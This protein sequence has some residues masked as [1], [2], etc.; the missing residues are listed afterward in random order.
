M[1][2]PAITKGGLYA[3]TFASY[4]L[5]DANVRALLS[6]NYWTSDA[7]GLEAATAFTYFFPTSADEY[8]DD[9]QDPSGL[10]AFKPTTQEQQ[11]ASEIG[12]RLITQFTGV[13][14]DL[15]EDSDAAIRVAGA[16]S[17]PG[18][19]GGS[20]ASY[21]Y[22][23]EGAISNSS[24]DVF[25]GDN[26]D[27]DSDQ[28][29][30]NDS[31]ATIIHE[32]GHAMGLK[33]P[34]E[35]FP[36][37]AISA[38]RSNI[39]F[40]VMSYSSFLSGEVSVNA[41]TI[42]PNG[43]SVSGYMMYDI[44]ALQAMYGANFAKGKTDTTPAE[45]SVYT[46]SNSTGQQYIN[47]EEAPDTGTTE[48]HKIFQTVW[49]QGADTTYD[50]SNFNGDQYD[51]LRAGQWLRFSVD[52]LA[53]LNS[54]APAG[55]PEYQAHGNVYNT[56][57]F[58]GE[59]KSLIGTLVAGGGN[60]TIIGNELA[61]VLHG[62]GGNDFIDG[63]IGKDVLYGGAGDDTLMGSFGTNELWGGEGIDTASYAGRSGIVHA[64][65]SAGYG[66]VNYMLADTYDSI[67]NLTAGLGRST[68]VGDAGANRLTG[69]ASS[70]LLYG[71][72]GNDMLIGGGINAG[73]PN[74][75][76]GQGGIDTASYEG[77]TGHVYADL[78]AQAGYV[79]GVLFDTMN[80]V[81][82]LIGGSTSDTL[83]GNAGANVLTG[84]G[85]GDALH[86]MGGA[87]IFVYL[88]F[89]D[90][91]LLTGYDTIFDFMSGTS[92]LDLTAFNT[93]ASHVQ[94]QSDGSSTSLYLHATVDVFNAPTDLAISFLGAN[95]IALSDILFA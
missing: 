15:A 25:L 88:Q 35:P 54:D 27:P 33:H 16:T 49:T 28:L 30:G 39:E 86:G 21:P 23:H 71:G 77:T 64:D 2:D 73:T 32:I 66:M 17:L 36:N 51:D 10:A 90:S 47:G 87:D 58:E 61:N 89:L 48:T 81:E 79:D 78:R 14:F 8:P 46:W 80:S 72:E 84:A 53:D 31:F 37:G 1:A 63:G 55:T 4:T 24:G 91:N 67:E 82:N 26:G 11:D 70:D 9:Y 7:D 60:D 68:L 92:K 43:S 38:D 65:L 57:L 13:S 83:I 6:N 44:A 18:N 41:N 50:L 94:I 74:Q 42:A 85:G 62:N 3:G 40:T 20:H 69:G 12:F 76:W 56:L 93:N 75:L 22:N 5:V 95:A 29:Y 34:F 59:T 19:E 52:Q 45:K